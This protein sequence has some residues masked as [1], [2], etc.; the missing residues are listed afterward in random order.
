[1][2]WIEIPIDSSI[3]VKTLRLLHCSDCFVCR[4]YCELNEMSTP[5]L[6]S[7]QHSRHQMIQSLRSQNAQKNRFIPVLMKLVV[8]VL[9]SGTL[10]SSLILWPVTQSHI[11]VSQRTVSNVVQPLQRALFLS[12][13]FRSKFFF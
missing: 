7:S 2:K 11:V 13:L 4:P 5:W 6:H 12:F 9:H 8:Q 3:A 10:C 1:M